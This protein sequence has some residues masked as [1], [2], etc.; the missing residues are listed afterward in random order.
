MLLY[1]VT[2]TVTPMEKFS[3]SFCFVIILFWVHWLS[4][5]FKDQAIM[6]VSLHMQI[7]DI[8]RAW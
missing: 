6:D 5:G 4:L 1:T 8:Y 3:W 7:T 2:Y